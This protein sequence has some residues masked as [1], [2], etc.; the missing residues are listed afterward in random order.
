MSQSILNSVK[1]VLG[2]NE[3]YTHFDQDIILHINSVFTILY[4]LGVGR[5]GFAISDNTATWNDYLG[6]DSNLEIVKS[7]VGLKVGMIFDPPLSS[8]VMEAKKAMIDE[9]EWRLNVAAEQANPDTP[10][11]PDDPLPE[12]V[13]DLSEEDIDELFNKN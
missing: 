9:M 5:K 2:I 3:D 13:E 4:E 8:A 1:K 10:I 12:G 6:N 11:N 7:Y